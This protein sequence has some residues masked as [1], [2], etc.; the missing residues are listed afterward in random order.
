MSRHKALARSPAVCL[1]F[2][3]TEH[4][5]AIEE[6]EYVVIQN[7]GPFE[8]RD[9]TPTVVAEARVN[10]DFEEAS[11][12]AFR[13]LFEYISSNDI[14]MTAP[15]SQEPAGDGWAV[16]FMMPA[17]Y[18]LADLPEADNPNVQIRKTP[19][20]RVATIRYS[21]AWSAENYNE[22]LRKLETWLEQ[23]GYEKTSD[24]VW[25]RYNSPYS[26]WFMR[27]N[28]I[29]IAINSNESRAGTNDD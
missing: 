12:K 5:V 9:Y 7:D 29:H 23:H 16:R 11:N 20:R 27:R 14:A 10:G 17:D 25:A 8:V 21:G 15:V 13:P 2:L 24:P 22:H 6:P 19:A 28:E 3:L 26:L 1:L 4:S 18:S